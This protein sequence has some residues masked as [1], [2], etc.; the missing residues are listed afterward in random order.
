M[1]IAEKGIVFV[2][3]EEGYNA[4]PERVKVEREVGKPIKGF[5]E[6]VPNSW[7]E[8]GYVRAE[9]WKN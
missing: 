6:K 2:L 1:E 7:L 8:K 4:T 5:E 3:T 9:E